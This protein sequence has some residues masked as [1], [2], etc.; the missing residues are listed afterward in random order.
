MTGKGDK[1][2]K[3]HDPIKISENM[4]KIKKTKDFTEGVEVVKKKTKTTYIFK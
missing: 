4:S 2:R 1:W 3:G